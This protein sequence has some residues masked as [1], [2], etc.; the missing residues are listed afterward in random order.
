M[1]AIVQIPLAIWETGYTKDE[2]FEADREGMHLAVRSGYSPYG[3][4]SM[5]EQ[6]S[7]LHDEYVVHA[8]NPEQELSQ[9]AI[10][11]LEGYFRSHPLPVERLAQ[12]NGIIAQEG[13]QDRKTQKPFRIEYEVHN[14][15]YVR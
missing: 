8:Q 4:V 14:G 13:W 3:A 7:K 10:Q 6:F 5:F 1:G 11:G 15:E 12:V 9:L 2:E